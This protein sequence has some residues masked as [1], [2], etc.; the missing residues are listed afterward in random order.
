MLFDAHEL[1]KIK[2]R[3]DFEISSLI[4]EVLYDI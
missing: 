3:N 1:I 2:E 4:E